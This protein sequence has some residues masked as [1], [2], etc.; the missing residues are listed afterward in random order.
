MKTLDIVRQIR[1]FV[2][3]ETRN[4]KGRKLV[5]FIFIFPVT[6]IALET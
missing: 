2:I 5:F 3:V 4:A 6:R 1:K